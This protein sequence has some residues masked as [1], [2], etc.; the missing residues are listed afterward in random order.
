MTR[1]YLLVVLA[2]ADLPAA[3][4]TALDRV[5]A[6][7]AF[8]PL[9]AALQN[10]LSKADAVAV[11]M[12]EAAEPV[13]DSVNL[14]LH[15]L[16]QHP[17]GTLIYGAGK[18]GPPQVAHPATLPVLY[19]HDADPGALTARLTT[20]LAMRASLDALQR[21][22]VASRRNS[23]TAARRYT[24]Q[25]RLASQVQR[26]FIPEHLPRFGRVSCDVLFHP[27][28]FVSGDIYDVHRLDDEH[29]AIALADAT[30]HGIPAALMTVYIKRAL[31]GKEIERGEYRILPPDEVLARL[32]DD[33]L[34]AELSECPFVA[35]MYG[36]LNTTTLEFRVAR[37]GAPF[38]IHRAADGTTRILRPAG[39]VV[40]VLP[41]ARFDVATVQLQ[42]GDA[43]VLYSDG[44]ERIVAPAE[45]GSDV[46]P[47]LRRLAARIADCRHIVQAAP[48]AESVVAASAESMMAATYATPPV[49]LA[50]PVAADDAGDDDLVA[51]S[52]WFSTLSA[53]GIDP[54]MEVVEERRRRLR[55][56]G[57]PLDDLTVLTLRVGGA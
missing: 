48:V 27:V 28:D 49:A 22:A 56:V 40:G 9:D 19:D 30:G 53:G 25:L 31:R 1:P 21:R 52:A 32:N 39:G 11:V 41:G 13:I 35:A 37:A 34:E 46:P 15:R 47:D 51:S 42:P 33:L 24:R 8:W 17:R 44:L 43:M 12:P 7:V 55:R 50:E 16:A 6:T 38:P 26:E 3:L 5:H 45:A 2:D 18:L 36:V 57:Y 10:N 54:A 14:L 29:V 4:R 23:E 20:L